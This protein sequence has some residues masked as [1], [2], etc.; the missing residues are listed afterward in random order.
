MLGGSQRQRRCAFGVIVLTLAVAGIWIA[1][2]ST[3]SSADGNL[4]AIVGTN[5]GFDITL[6]DANGNKVARLAPART[7]SWCTIVRRCTTS[8]SGATPIRPSTSAQARVRR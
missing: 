7:R 3:R 1:P 8:I 2:A 4:E 6:N 5:D